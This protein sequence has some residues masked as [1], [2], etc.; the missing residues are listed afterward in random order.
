MTTYTSSDSVEAP[1]PRAHWQHFVGVVGWTLRDKPSQE[2]VAEAYIA[3]IRARG[4][5]QFNQALHDDLK[6]NPGQIAEMQPI[7]VRLIGLWDTVKRLG[8][9]AG[10]IDLT[11]YWTK[12]HDNPKLP[13]HITHA[14]HAL[15][16]HDLRPEFE[17][18]LWEDWEKSQT[19]HQVWFPGA[20]SDVG[21]GYTETDLSN[22]A[23]T[24]MASQSVLYGLELKPGELPVPDKN[25]FLGKVHQEDKIISALRSRKILSAWKSLPKNKMIESFFIHETACNRLLHATTREYWSNSPRPTLISA[26]DS[27]YGTLLTNVD[28][29]ALTL[30]LG[31]SIKYSKRP[32]S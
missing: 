4:K 9:E 15:A 25:A 19:L 32:I 28:Q 12:H 23:L 21:G 26:K 13:A 27:N 16:L 30:H 20:H 7:L 3:Y 6:I 11:H 14:R 24:W 8:V 2:K 1:L 29:L 22:A 18:T 17:P 5:E 10:N 31:L